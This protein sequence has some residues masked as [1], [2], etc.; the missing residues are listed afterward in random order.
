MGSMP[1]FRR[2]MRAVTK[3]WWMVALV[4]T[5][6]ITG[7]Y[8]RLG[9]VPPEYKASTTVMITTSVPF[10]GL[11]SQ[12]QN[13]NGV[14]LNNVQELIGTRT[15]T[16]RVASALDVQPSFV[17]GNVTAFVPRGTDLLRIRTTA[18][19]GAQAA[20]LAN[21]TAKEL[22]AYFR[23]LN[24]RDAREA[25]QFIESQMPSVRG[26]LESVDRALQAARRDPTGLQGGTNAAMSQY[27][28]AAGALADAQVTR[29][30]LEARLKSVTAM[31]QREQPFMVSER[32][33]LDNPVFRQ[34]ESRMIALEVQRVQ[35]SQVYTSQHPRMQQIEAETVALKE[36]LGTTAQTSLG[37]EVSTNN[38]VHARL[39]QDVAGLRMERLAVDARIAALDEV[40]RTRR[41]QVATIPSTE[42]KVARLT[43]DQQILEGNYRMLA[44]N[45]QEAI[46]R[47]NIAKFMP[48]G[49]Q[50][51]EPAVAPTQPT[52]RPVA[53]TAGVAGLAGLLFGVVAAIFLEATDSSI[54]T[55]EDAERTLGV[56]VLAQIPNANEPRI[57]PANALFAALFLIFLLVSTWGAFARTRYPA[58]NWTGQMM[59]EVV[60]QPT[61]SGVQWVTGWT[62]GLR[63][64]AG[65]SK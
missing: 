51:V 8:Y 23:E 6:A 30:E 57:A 5:I 27:F 60:I 24:S 64:A 9:D 19:S 43:R 4:V 56:P 16:N 40:V 50:I 7:V 42:A 39:L 32:A 47:E 12:S 18:S 22:S 20:A 26:R 65:Q 62:Y 3:R 52:P 44:T 53:K 38:P 45:M 55:A 17:D 33:M 59:R 11:G 41:Q 36:L 46:L 48:A 58:V 37:R 25:R 63:A 28:A 34:Y 49:V 61:M 10:G 31:L 21:T 13:R 35:L 15:M 54:R 14:M 2:Y 29:R 1:E